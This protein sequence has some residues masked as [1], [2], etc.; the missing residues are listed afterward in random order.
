MLMIFDHLEKLDVKPYIVKVG[1]LVTDLSEFKPLN[2]EYVKQFG[3]R[4]PVRVCIGIPGDEVIGHFTVWNNDGK[5]DAEAL[6]RFQSV[7]QNVHVQSVS[8]WAPPNVGPYSQINK[9]DNMIFLAGHIGLYPPAL[10]LVDGGLMAQ[11]HQI[12]KNYN[13]ALRELC[14]DAMKN[15][16]DLHWQDLCKSAIIFVP[17]D[18]DIVTSGL[19]D[20][21][22]KDFAFIAKNTVLI[23]VSALPIGSQV[24]VEFNCDSSAIENF[25]KVW[26]NEPRQLLYE[27]LKAY[28]DRVDD[29]HRNV[30][31]EVFH[32][33]DRVTRDEIVA[34]SGQKN[35]LG[36]TS[37]IPALEIVD[38]FANKSYDICERSL[39]H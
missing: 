5:N 19:M 26:K 3:L 24:E 9:L 31:G 36:V 34:K 29:L 21:I 16:E 23:R 10:A 39:L 22:K 38:V 11:Y 6:E 15:P 37:I 17:A 2:A 4:P 27:D 35:I 25:D 28:E 20:A 32:V 12:K 14:K 13:T 1:L 18:A 7:Q 8:H 30:Y 33:K